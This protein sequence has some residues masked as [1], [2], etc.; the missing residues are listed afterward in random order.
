MERAAST[1]YKL[2]A[3]WGRGN[4]KYVYS[5]KIIPPPLHK[6]K[7]RG[8]KILA[9][10][11][12][13]S[14]ERV[15]RFTKKI[16]SPQHSSSPPWN[17]GGFNTRSLKKIIKEP[18][19][20][21]KKVI[22]DDQLSP[23]CNCFYCF[24]FKGR[25]QNISGRAS[26]AKWGNCQPQQQEDAPNA[27]P[28]KGDTYESQ[29]SVNYIVLPLCSWKHKNMNLRFLKGRHICPKDPRHK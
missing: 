4:D 14:H 17:K 6:E 8:K 2:I 5:K 26:K 11:N 10:T 28:T 12:S 3:P 18:S 25:T 24:C 15:E 20:A 27:N 16:V 29:K 21:E 13:R 23:D 9:D 22:S 19:H 1:S 7:T